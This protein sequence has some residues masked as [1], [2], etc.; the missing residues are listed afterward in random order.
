MILSNSIVTKHKTK[1]IMRYFLSIVFVVCCSGFASAQT[2]NTATQPKSDSL[3][4]VTNP[5][6][7]I[8]NA[9]TISKKGLFSIYKTDEKYYFEIPDSLLGREL[10]LT[11]WLVQV[12]GGSPKYGGEVLNTRVISFEKERD[13]I[14]LKVVT[15]VTEPD[16]TNTI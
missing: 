4:A 3:K 10:M 11:T 15:E 8:V 12:P 5:L 6:N 2:K 7:N 9:K 1:F 16:S 13:K 14:A